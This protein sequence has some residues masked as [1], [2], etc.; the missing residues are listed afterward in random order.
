M[1]N[2]NQQLVGVGLRSNHYPDIENEIKTNVDWFEAISENYMNTQ[3]RPLNMLL[4]VRE[5]YPVALHG[6]GMSIGTHNGQSDKYLKKLKA[7]IEKVEPHIVTDHLCWSGVGGHF[8]H[9]LLPFPFTQ[10]ALKTIVRNIQQVQEF[11]GRSI[12]LENISY[13]LKSNSDEM[14]E[15]DFIN[16]VCR[17]TGCGLLLDLNNIDVNAQNHKFSAFEFLQRLNIQ[18]VRQIHLA[19]PSQEEGFVFDTHSSPVPNSVWDLYKIF[20]QLKS[21]VPV[22]IEW[23][24]N[25]PA[26]DIL[27]NEANKVKFIQE[28]YIKSSKIEHRDSHHG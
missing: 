17:Q 1:I 26:F 25:I 22:I 10:D 5:T 3:G 9:D 24:E 4:K 19:G 16:E 11:L 2:K 13:Y 8:S 21:N 15:T 14:S 12:S 7:L 28:S 27:E 6:V 18:N 20:I 23:D